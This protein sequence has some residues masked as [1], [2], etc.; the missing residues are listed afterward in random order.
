MERGEFVMEQDATISPTFAFSRVFTD[1]P[2]IFSTS[3]IVAAV[4]VSAI[5]G[6]VFG[7]I[8]ARNAAQLDPLEALA[9][10]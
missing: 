4:A 8:P 1:F 7:F 9:R 3:S 10:E 6:V 2:M 5:I